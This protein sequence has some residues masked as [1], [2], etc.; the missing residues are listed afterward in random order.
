MNLRLPQ[1]RSRLTFRRLLHVDVARI[2]R[3]VRVL[4]Q[5]LR[6]LDDGPEP[7]VVEFRRRREVRVPG[8]DAGT[9]SPR[10]KRNT[11]WEK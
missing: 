5:K 1:S 3:A 2:D 8:T 9:G 6:Q 7:L 11:S 4:E 10:R